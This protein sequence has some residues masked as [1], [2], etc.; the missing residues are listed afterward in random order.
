MQCA[1]NIGPPAV[2]PKLS[3]TVAKSVHGSILFNKWVFLWQMS[4]A[5]RFQESGLFLGDE[6]FAC[7]HDILTLVSAP[8]TIAK[9]RLERAHI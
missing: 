6:G 9:K 8:E 4:K 3:G 1:E 5:I 2:H 7:S